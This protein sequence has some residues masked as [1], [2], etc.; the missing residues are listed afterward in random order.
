MM[1]VCQ[2]VCEYEVLECF[3]RYY[4][5][6]MNT[7]FI[8][9][10]VS[11][12]RIHTQTQIHILTRIRC[13][14]PCFRDFYSRNCKVYFYP[15][16]TRTRMRYTTV[17]HIHTTAYNKQSIE[18]VQVRFERMKMAR[19]FFEKTKLVC[20]EMVFSIEEI[21]EKISE[22]ALTIFEPRSL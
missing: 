1:H 5:R 3:P 18:N 6:C 4:M 17:H 15:S 11:F 20:N 10:K 8:E 7:S 21:D 12:Y 9:S 13:T 14:L 19:H 2:Y 22:P 16:I